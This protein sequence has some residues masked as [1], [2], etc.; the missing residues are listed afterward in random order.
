MEMAI[1]T[2]AKLGYNYISNIEYIQQ[3]F[4]ACKIYVLYCALHYIIPHVYV[5]FCVPLTIVGAF[6]SPFISQSPHCIA[7]RYVLYTL[8]DY[9]RVMFVAVAGWLASK[10]F[11][12]VT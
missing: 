4:N 11:I 3:I 9:I 10:I 1:Y 6:M 8:G 12:N 2:Y 7:L 5:Y